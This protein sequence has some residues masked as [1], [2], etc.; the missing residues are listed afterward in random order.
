MPLARLAAPLVAAALAL[1]GC[2]A[3]TT[4]PDPTP[5]AQPLTITHARGT[6]EVPA[7]PRRVVV[8]DHAS[9]DTLQALGLGDRVVGTPTSPLPPSL[10][11]F[12]DAGAVGTL[13]EP[14]IEAIATLDPDVV[15]LGG[16]SAEKY[17]EVSQLAPTVLLTT[18]NAAPLE[19]L[20][21]NVTTLGAMFGVEDAAASE[22]GAVTQLVEQTRAGTQGGPRALIVLTSGGKVSAFGPGARFGSLIHDALGVTPAATD[23]EASQHG[24]AIS[25]EYIAETS[26]EALFVVDRDAAIGQEGAS[27]RQVLDN[28]LVARTPA[29]QHGRVTYLD[30][31]DWYLVGYGL[32]S[33]R[34]MI[35]AVAGAVAP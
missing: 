12:A 4:P 23:L 33:T 29:W 2:A 25:F 6:T 17:D 18:D 21:S 30:G 7:D 35:E 14:D 16:R 31:A 11:E 28:P 3:P 8:V 19:S 1:T 24:Q 5:V 20:R 26:P 10:A 34:R 22:L 9:L 15:I 32:G 27:A 13:A